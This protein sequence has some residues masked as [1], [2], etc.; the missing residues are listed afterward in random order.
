MLH[1]KAGQQTEKFIAN[2]SDDQWNKES[3]IG[4]TVKQLVNHLVYEHLWVDDLVSGKTIAEVGDKYEGDVLGKNPLTAF[5]KAFKKANN[6]FAKPGALEKIVHLSFG[7]IKAQVYAEQIFTDT[8]IHGWDIA[9]SSNQSD[10]LAGELVEA[11]YKLVLPEEQNLRASGMFG[12]KLDVPEDADLQ[13]KLLALLG[14][15]R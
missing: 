9:K 15:K 12:E 4:W 6:A 2:I 10:I 8:L 11:G 1:K 13:T 7:D 14:R 3:N 5:K